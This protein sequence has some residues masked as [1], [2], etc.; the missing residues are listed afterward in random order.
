[1]PDD[2]EIEILRG[3][4]SW[5]QQQTA[6]QAHE[7]LIDLVY[8]RDE[9]ARRLTVIVPGQGGEERPEPPPDLVVVHS[10]DFASLNEHV[11]SNFVALVR[12][13]GPKRLLLHNPP[14]P[15]QT[16]LLRAIPSTT[17]SHYAYPTISLETLRAIRDNFDAKLIGQAHVKDQLLAALYP[18]TR[19]QSDRPV[20]LMFCGPSGVGKTETARFVNEL[21]G[22]PL[23]RKQ[24][25]MFHSEKFA[26]YLFGGD[27]SEP[28]LA[29]DLLDRESGV[30][31]I[32]EFDKANPVFHS[33]FYQ[34][35][36]D[37]V[38]VDKNYEVH[39]G[40]ALV[41]CTSNYDSRRQVQD[42]L[43][44]ALY[45]RFDAVVE[46][47]HLDPADVLRIVEMQVARHWARLTDDE[48]AHLDRGELTKLLAPLATNSSNVRTIGK[49]V[50]ELVCRKLVD[51]MLVAGG[52]NEL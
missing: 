47:Q 24:F 1:M 28:S 38:Y 11:I 39:V 32:D 51:A 18:L 43:G 21:L 40:A 26:S 27:H 35:F 23:F 37:G 8:Q 42:S 10:G 3:P 4:L 13:I 29:R 22:G 36:E 14:A 2:I 19:A 52:H 41:V 6:D 44:D 12:A 17:V 15:V 46:F 49:T 30:I 31:L 33:A 7:R 48:R 5:F 25:S 50:G 20:V 9:R 45:S 34:L 16:Q